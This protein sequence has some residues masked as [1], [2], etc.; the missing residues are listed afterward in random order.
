MSFFH[1]YERALPAVAFR[2]L[3]CTADRCS[4]KR[5]PALLNMV[6]ESMNDFSMEC[7]TISIVDQHD[8]DSTKGKRQHSVMLSCC[9]VLICSG[10]M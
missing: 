3:R 5:V 6:D 9:R 7:D 10:V 8:S 4:N 2:A 1:M